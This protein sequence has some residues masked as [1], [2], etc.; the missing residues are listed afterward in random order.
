MTAPSCVSHP[1]GQFLQRETFPDLSG[2][3]ENFD[4]GILRPPDEPPD[5]QVLLAHLCP[6]LAKFRATTTLTVDDVAQ[7]IIYLGAAEWEKEIDRIIG[8]V[9]YH[10]HLCAL[11]DALTV[12]LSAKLS[13]GAASHSR[14]KI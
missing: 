5:L 13:A 6:D 4:P 9:Q 1:L 2:S 14:I 11:F 10:G 3:R 7:D 8:G 12:A